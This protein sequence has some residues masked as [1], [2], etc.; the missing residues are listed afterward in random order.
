M[1]EICTS[2]SVGAPGAQAPGA[3]R[4]ELRYSAHD[5][6]LHNRNDEVQ[7]QAHVHT[8]ESTSTR[9][10]ARQ[11]HVLVPDGKLDLT[12]ASDP[13]QIQLVAKAFLVHRFEQ[14]RARSSVDFDRGADDLFREVFLQ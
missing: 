11:F 4:R 10:P 7:Q 5:P 9:Y 1:R 8:A 6:T 3:T 12:L 14:S 13:S 2:G